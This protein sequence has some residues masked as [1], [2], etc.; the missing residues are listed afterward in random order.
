[1]VKWKM[2]YTTRSILGSNP[3]NAC[4]YMYKYMDQKGLTAMSAVKRSAG[5]SEESIAHK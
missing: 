1:M 2:H 3:T 5:E 4:T